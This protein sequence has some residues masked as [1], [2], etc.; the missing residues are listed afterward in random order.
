[1]KQISIFFFIFLFNI[2]NVL[3]DEKSDFLRWKNEFKILAI[4][5]NISEKTFDTVMSSVKFYQKL[6]SMIDINL[7][8]MKILKLIFQKE[9]LKKKFLKG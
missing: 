5:N 2:S 9:L 7:S 1:M 3:G 6:S 4:K 8:F